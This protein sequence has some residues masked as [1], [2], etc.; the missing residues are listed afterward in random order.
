MIYLKLILGLIFCFLGYCYLYRPQIIY[1]LNDSLKETIFNNSYI[2]MIRY[3]AALF[4]WLMGLILIYMA[5]S[6]LN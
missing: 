2:S 3:K 4:F 1:R 6:R 5:L